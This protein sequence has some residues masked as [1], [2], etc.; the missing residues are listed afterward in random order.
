MA[1]DTFKSVP[2]AI[3]Q[4][5]SVVG[6][7]QVTSVTTSTIGAPAASASLGAF[8]DKTITGAKLG[9]VVFAQPAEALPTNQHFL[10]AYVVATDTVRFQFLATG[11]AVTGAAKNFYVGL[12]HRS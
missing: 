10:G 3:E 1:L 2:H 11:G 8:V 6:G 7:L 5:L 9:D 12:W 4:L